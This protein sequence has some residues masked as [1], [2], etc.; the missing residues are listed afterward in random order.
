VTVSEVAENADCG[1]RA[2]KVPPWARA[3]LADLAHLDF[4][5]PVARSADSSEL[6][7]FFS[8]GCRGRLARMASCPIRIRAGV[9]QAGACGQHVIQVARAERAHR[10]H[11][12][13]HWW[14]SLGAPLRFSWPCSSCAGRHGGAREAPGA[15]LAYEHGR[16]TQAF[17]EIDKACKDGTRCRV[18][19]DVIA[20]GE[21]DGSTMFYSIVRVT[22]AQKAE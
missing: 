20:S 10:G 18:T 13:V 12:D 9:Q 17:T 7:E 16:K 6:S 1:E 3:I 11:A 2:P 5:A 19:A 14:S 15:A 22:H 4:E 21:Y 8:G